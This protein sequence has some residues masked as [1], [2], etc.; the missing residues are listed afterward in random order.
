MSQVWTENFRVNV[1]AAHG[2]LPDE[3]LALAAQIAATARRMQGHE[4]DD[5]IP[6]EACR[7]QFGD[8]CMYSICELCGQ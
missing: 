2:L 8:K 7:T 6:C 5:E 1:D 4:L 3:A